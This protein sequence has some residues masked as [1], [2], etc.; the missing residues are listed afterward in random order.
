MD[1]P[2]ARPRRLPRVPP[3]AQ[4]AADRARTPLPCGAPCRPCPVR[5]AARAVARGGRVAPRRRGDAPGVGRG[6]AFLFEPRPPVAAAREHAAGHRHRGGVELARAAPHR[7]LRG[8]AGAPRDAARGGD[9][10]VRRRL[11]ALR[12]LGSAGS[13]AGAGRNAGRRAPRAQ[14]RRHRRHG[15]TRHDGARLLRAVAAGE[16]RGEH[17]RR[18]ASSCAC[19]SSHSRSRLSSSRAT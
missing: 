14:E 4:G 11:R 5:L 3:A 6:G 10:D 15:R 18:Q 19:F 1:V 7:A 17:E 9:R 16:P 13:A 8:S 12:L 2:A